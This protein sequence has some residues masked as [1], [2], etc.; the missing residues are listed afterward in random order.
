MV[1]RVLVRLGW[2]W[3]AGC[4]LFDRAVLVRYAVYRGSALRV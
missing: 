3:L 4:G 2:R 1:G